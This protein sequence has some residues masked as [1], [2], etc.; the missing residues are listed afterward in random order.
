MNLFAS[1][2]LDQ[3]VAVLVETLLQAQGIDATCTRSERMLDQLDDAQ[4][5]FA[6]KNKRCLLTHNG[7]DFEDLHAQYLHEGRFHFGIIIAI[8]RPPHQI[9]RNVAMLVNQLTADEIA[10]NLLYV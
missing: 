8:R 5:A 9:A 3:D 6:V 4:I 1:L 10:N 7:R 2:Y